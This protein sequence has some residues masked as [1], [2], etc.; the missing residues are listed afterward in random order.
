MRLSENHV[1]V[2]TVYFTVE[3]ERANTSHAATAAG[4]SYVPRVRPEPPLCSIV[5]SVQ[6][7]L[8]NLL[9]RSLFNR[10]GAKQQQYHTRSILRHYG[11]GETPHCG[12]VRLA[13]QLD[14]RRVL[15]KFFVVKKK[16]ALLGLE[17]REKLRIVN[18]VNAVDDSDGYASLKQTYS[19]L[20]TGNGRTQLEYKTVLQEDA[21]PVVQP[22]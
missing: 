21:V 9:P 22:L 13:V 17:A 14:Q 15:L 6:V 10:L 11:G 4:A 19:R 16:Q 1:P 20:F 12:K 2:S 5:V 3:S 18:R 7:D 8:A